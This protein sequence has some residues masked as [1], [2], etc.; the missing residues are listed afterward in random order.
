MTPQKQK[1]RHKPKEGLI[2]DCHRTCYACLL[3]I[4]RDSIPNFGEMGFDITKK[5]GGNHDEFSTACKAWLT[6]QG[7]A[8]F[9]VGFRSDLQDVF[10]F[11]ASCNPGQYYILGGLSAT[12]V[13]HSVIG[14]DDQIVWDPSLTD[15]GIVEPCE[16]DGLYW[17]TILSPIS[18]I[19]H[20][21]V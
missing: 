11:M 13:N 14:C 4:D 20:G 1:N 12:G 9:M 10:R 8:Q 19:K 18:Q 5:G 17:I 15:A 2:G 21:G 16:P 6:S 7:Y 3:D